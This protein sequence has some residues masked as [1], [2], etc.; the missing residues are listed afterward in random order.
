MY[1]IR[2]L[3]LPTVWIAVGAIVAAI[4]DYFDTLG[5]TGKIL[6]AVAAIV[7]WPMLPF[8]FEIKVAR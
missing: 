6:T 8:G 4:Y 2:V 3:F 1:A 5:T 7:L